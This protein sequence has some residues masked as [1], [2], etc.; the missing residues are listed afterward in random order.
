MRVD[1][2]R[3]VETFV[4][5]TSCIDTP[6]DAEPSKIERDSSCDTHCRTFIPESG[7][8]FCGSM[9]TQSTDRIATGTTWSSANTA[10]P[11]NK[12]T[13]LS[14]SDPARLSRPD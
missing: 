5:L 2:S 6:A 9:L 11:L 12:V 7:L 8:C 1:K 14:A 13:I 4:L 3:T 10:M